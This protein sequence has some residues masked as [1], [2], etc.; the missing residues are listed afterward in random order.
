MSD[1]FLSRQSD[2]LN[3]TIGDVHP[4]FTGYVEALVASRRASVAPIRGGDRLLPDPSRSRPSAVTR[5][6]ASDERFS[7]RRIRERAGG[8]L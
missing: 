1:E 7:T 3:R 4:E 6:S 2:L 5:R 8:S